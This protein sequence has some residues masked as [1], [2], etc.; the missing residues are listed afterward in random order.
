MQPPSQLIIYFRQS[1]EE[2]YPGLCDILAA[3]IRFDLNGQIVVLDASKVG[4]FN[5]MV[6]KFMIDN[7]AFVNVR[8]HFSRTSENS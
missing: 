7:V 3:T 5:R 2:S 1:I 4:Q 6:D 8:L